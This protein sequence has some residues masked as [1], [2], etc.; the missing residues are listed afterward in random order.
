MKQFH[1]Y[2]MVCV[3]SLLGISLWILC[4]LNCM[5]SELHN[6]KSPLCVHLGWTPKSSFCMVIIVMLKSKFYYFFLDRI[7]K[8]VFHVLK[9]ISLKFIF[10]WWTFSKYHGFN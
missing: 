3:R 6:S 2:S 9:Y 4:N 8:A 1:W 5:T 7:F 10:E